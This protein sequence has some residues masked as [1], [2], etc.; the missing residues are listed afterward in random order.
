MKILKLYRSENYGR[1]QYCIVF[2]EIPQLTYEK[3]DKDYVGSAVDHE[4]NI[5]LSLHLGYEAAGEA[6]AG[7]ELTLNMKDGT[8]EKIKNHWFDWGSY[9]PHGEFINV[10]ANTLENL[11]NCYVYRG[12]NINKNAFMKMLEDYYSRD[13]E[14][15][16]C[17]IQTWCRLQHKW[18]DVYIDGKNYPY[19]VNKKGEFI[20]K[21]SKKPIFHVRRN[22]GIGKYKYKGKT[23]NKF[24][25]CIF[26]LK[27]NN[28]DRLVKVE[29]NMLDV[30]K[31]SLPYSE[32][33]IIKNCDLEEY[34]KV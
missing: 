31:E 7:S 3:I 28:G 16:D 17:E 13:K 4:G 14:Y 26:K 6:F 25:L 15:D 27:Y 11:Q 29:R 33:E 12:Y 30:L 9:K 5:L 20:H 18:Y 24:K 8:V 19:M 32:D 23:N 34:Y 2:D 22:Y 21:D 10:G 1:T